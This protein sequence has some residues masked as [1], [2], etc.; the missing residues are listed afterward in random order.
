MRPPTTLVAALAFLLVLPSC[1]S[2][3]RS[4][5][6]MLRELRAN[7]VTTDDRVKHPA[8]AGALNLLPGIGNFYLA[9][10]TEETDQW[11]I[12]FLNLLFWPLS[13]TWAVPEAAIDA[14]SINKKELV[15]Y[16]MYD[17]HGRQAYAR[18]KR[19]GEPRY[20]AGRR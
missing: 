10:G 8:V 19:W 2:L 16:Y 11:A 6:E 4:E 1:V 12:G 13:V 5:R 14:V 15:Y 17:H 18:M 7:G 20:R 9:T 3:S